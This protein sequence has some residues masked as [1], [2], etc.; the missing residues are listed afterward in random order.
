MLQLFKWPEKVANAVLSGWSPTINGHRLVDGAKLVKADADYAVFEGVL[1]PGAAVWVWWRAR[2]EAG[3]EKVRFWFQ[4][5][6]G[7][8]ADSRPRIPRE[9]VVFSDAGVSVILE[10]PDQEDAEV[11]QGQGVSLSTLVVDFQSPGFIRDVYAP[12]GFTP[13]KYVPRDATQ[14]GGEW[15]YMGLIHDV[16]NEPLDFWREQLYA[17]GVYGGKFTDGK[18]LLTELDVPEAVL[19]EG[20]FHAHARDSG[21]IHYTDPANPWRDRKAFAVVEADTQHN[22]LLDV[23]CQAYLAYPEDEGLAMLAISGAEYWL[24]ALPGRAKGTSH[25]EPGQERAQGRNLK[26]FVWLHRAFRKMGN[27]PLA[28]RIAARTQQIWHAQRDKA[29]ERYEASGLPFTHYG[30]RGVRGGVY[31][32][33]EV[34]IHYWGLLMLDEELRSLGV[35]DGDLHALMGA[36]REFCYRSFGRHWGLTWGFPWEVTQGV[37]GAIRPVRSKRPTSPHFAY[38]AAAHY[39]HRDS[40]GDSDGDKTKALEQIGDDIE[41]RFKTWR[42]APSPLTRTG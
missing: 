11:L 23:V 10:A 15:P 16:E 12:R 37:T 9:T 17:M 21:H 30:E 8:T 31:N 13:T 32:P 28:E 6:Y 38:L 29:R 1:F 5:G 2:I 4:P 19:H 26:C 3:S 27:A 18:K 41:D 25:H 40:D 22:S 42:V 20:R 7:S 14:T 34:G 39:E 35:E 33:S 24:M 36:C